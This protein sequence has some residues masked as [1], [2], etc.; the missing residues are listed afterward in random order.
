[1][2]DGR[3]EP[4]PGALLHRHGD[5]AE[6]TAAR[7]V[8][9]WHLFLLDALTDRIEASLLDL[10]PAAAWRTTLTSAEVWADTPQ[11]DVPMPHTHSTPRPGSGEGCGSNMT[12]WFVAEGQALVACPPR[13]RANHPST[14]SGTIGGCPTEGDRPAR[15]VFVPMRSSGRR[16]RLLVQRAR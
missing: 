11:P 1:M 5:G 3:D 10:G 9:P 13:P 15:T 7:V 12:P 16:L 14:S 8:R 2:G 6:C 4:L